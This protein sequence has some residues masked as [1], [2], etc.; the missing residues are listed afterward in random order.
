MGARLLGIAVDQ[1]RRDV[2]AIVGQPENKDLAGQF[3]I[4]WK[5]D[6][7]ETYGTTFAAGSK[8]TTLCAASTKGDVRTLYRF[9]KP[10]SSEGEIAP[11]R[12][13]NAEAT[14]RY[15]LDRLADDSHLHAS[16]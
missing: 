4:V 10:D 15:I 16:K 5:G 11:Q 8:G 12:N 9:N 2:Y 14:L 3:V 7:G 1:A 6:E 13:Q